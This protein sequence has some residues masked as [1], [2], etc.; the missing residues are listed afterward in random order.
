[1][2]ETDSDSSHCSSS[3]DFAQNKG[4]VVPYN[5]EK[6]RK[7]FLEKLRKNLEEYEGH[8]LKES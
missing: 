3:D 2:I 6:E 7:V 1:M 8:A 4:H 5:Q